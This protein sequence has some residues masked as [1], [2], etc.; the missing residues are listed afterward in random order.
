MAEP[1]HRPRSTDP[2]PTPT[3]EQNPSRPLRP[4][5]RVGDPTPQPDSTQTRA[6]TEV[7]DAI[8]ANL[9]RHRIDSLDPENI[10]VGAL[11]YQPAD[12]VARVLDIVVDD[13][14]AA[15]MPRA[16][17]RTIRALVA[18]GL[19]P[20]PMTV[21]AALRNPAASAEIPDTEPFPA[22]HE[23]LTLFVADAYHHALAISIRSAARQVVND[24]YLRGFA[25]HGM[26]ILQMAEAHAENEDLEAETLAHIRRQHDIRQRLDAII[27]G[28]SGA[29]PHR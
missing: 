25:E 7:T 1:R 24:R 26:R 12:V 16:V 13:D 4:V 6:E 22:R 2:P 19:D 11:M 28:R 14:M 5:P 23:R 10:L 29:A 3:P 18:R 9:I 8:V 20:D 15:A 27:E 17:L 21:A